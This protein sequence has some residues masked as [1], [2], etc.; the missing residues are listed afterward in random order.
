MVSHRIRRLDARGFSLAELIVVCAV[1]GILT[2]VGMPTF[3]TYWRQSQ[4][5]GGAQELVSLLNQGRQIAI[6][7]N[8]SVCIKPSAS[9]GSYGTQLQYLRDSACSASST[10][11]ATSN[12]SPCIWVGPGTDANGYITLSN[13][14]EM[15]AS[16][17]VVFGYLG[18]ATTA[19]TYTVRAMDNTSGTSTVTVA[20]SGRISY[21]FP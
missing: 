3:I 21:A 7:E 20:A 4:L 14:I 5:K 16:T 13:R 12:V 17:N 18:S 8:E 6:K 15:N 9:T 2:A 1:I 10:C 11:T 19:G